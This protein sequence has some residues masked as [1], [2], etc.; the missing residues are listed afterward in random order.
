[1]R[2]LQLIDS[3]EIGGAEKM[4]VNYA[5]ALS[6]KIEFSCLVATRKEGNL[7]N[8]LYKNVNYLFLNKKSIVDIKAILKLRAFCL[9][10]KITHI[11]SHGSSYFFSVL[12]KITLPKV[13]IIWHDHNGN[14]DNEGFLKEYSLLLSSYF[15]SGVMTVNKELERIAKKNLKLKKIICLPN[16]TIF[17]EFEN[18]NTF[19]KGIDGKRII[20]LANLRHPKNH[21]FCIELAKK[22]KDIY[23]DWSFHLVGKDA[24]DDY[25]TQLKNIIKDSNLEKQVFIY[26]QKQDV[27]HI[28]SQSNI[29]L[30]TST[31][32]GLPVAVLEYGI[33]KVALIASNVGDIPLIVENNLSGFLCESNNSA[34]FYKSLIELIEN[35]FLRIKFGQQLYNKIAINYSKDAVIEKY[36]NWLTF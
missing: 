5:N 3:L 9:I 31:S 22:I 7:K 19:L 16:F 18:K 2:I 13:V 20:I 1:M 21:L 12:L 25:S 30:I 6:E 27:F 34:I 11:H 32:E 10:N 35:S 15:F 14:R 29:A 23:P 17:N 4:A 26:G 8:Q 28:L 33:G 24:N 36:L